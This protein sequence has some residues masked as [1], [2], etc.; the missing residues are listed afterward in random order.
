M[1][2]L[3]KL[4]PLA[5]LVG[6]WEGAEG[7]D[8]SFSHAKGGAV[9][10]PFRERASFAPLGPVKN[11]SQELYGLDYRTEAIRIGEDEPFHTEVGYWLWD[12]A[13]GEVMRCFLVPRGSALIAG[14]VTEPDAL[15]F[16]MRAG[17]G[18][19]DYG[20]LSN[21]YLD[22]VAKAVKFEVELDLRDG[23]YAY[24]EDTQ[25]EFQGRGEVFHHTDRNVLT[26]VA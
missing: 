21:R 5:P 22:R 9:E 23:R 15:Q 26:K 10:T 1:V 17:L 13:D 19:N 24:Q 4:G 8:V 18:A 7:L 3:T 20:I 11:G 12:A 16:T 25:L 14:C 2:D 6:T